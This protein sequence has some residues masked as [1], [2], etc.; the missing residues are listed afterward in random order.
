MSLH[1]TCAVDYPSGSD[2]VLIAD[3][4]LTAALNDQWADGIHGSARLLIRLHTV[5]LGELVV[6]LDGDVPADEVARRVW[7]QL[8]P[9]IREHLADDGL[10]APAGLDRT[11]LPD[12]S[13]PACLRERQQPLGGAAA[14]PTITVVVA[15]RDRTDSLL[16][17]L[18]ALERVRYDAFDVVLV[19]SCPSGEDTAV[20]VREH[21]WSFPLRYVRADRP[22]LAIAHN[23]AL[24]AVTGE[25]V[26][27]TDDDVEVDPHWLAAVAG[28]FADAEVT[29]VTGL[30]LPA[31]LA[32]PA[33]LLVEESGG[34][35]RGFR[36][37]RF[38]LAQPPP[39]PLFPFTVGR[40][41]SGAN[42]AFRTAWLRRVGGFD[43]ATGT[44]T[45][46]RGGDD[47]AAFLEVL[48]DGG[49]IAYQPAAI[50]RHWH[51]REYAALRN[52]AYGY[53]HGL[54]A[55][56]TAALIRRPRLVLSMLR[57]MP[58]AVRYLR[59][60]SSAKNRDKGPGYPAELSALER[61][62]QLHGPYGYLVSRRLHRDLRHGAGRG[63]T[64][65]RIDPAAAGAR[66]GSRS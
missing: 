58:R 28:P 57:R 27:F 10:P 48:L 62:G 8:G 45:P 30:I 22:G 18:A 31:E 2:P 24:P 5:P 20:A 60:P 25:L 53:G 52:Q 4:E 34:F 32:T 66:T 35:A 12:Q 65:E 55:Y 39:D 42:M 51:R 44:G 19:D 11:G 43:P 21:S 33:Q 64:V 36:P 47:L 1:E 7:A 3:L 23:T 59:D 46:A 13:S 61:S 50:V 17:C 16:R 9:A 54:S 37:R 14:L 6:P 26:A 56:L 63:R 38:S 29:C 41:G 49:V 15:T 40:C